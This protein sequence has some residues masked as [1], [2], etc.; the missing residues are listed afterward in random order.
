MIEKHYGGILNTEEHKMESQSFSPYSCSPSPISGSQGE[1]LV[2][3][4]VACM[5]VNHM[6]TLLFL[7]YYF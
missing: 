1:I 2:P 3:L 4:L 6:L 7:I 5:N